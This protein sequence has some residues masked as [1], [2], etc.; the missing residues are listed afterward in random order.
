MMHMQST[1]YAYLFVSFIVL[2]MSS[3]I[4]WYW[5]GSV[6]KKNSNF[7]FLRIIMAFFGVLLCI[8]LVKI[9][10]K[11]IAGIFLGDDVFSVS[12][13]VISI[14]V[15]SAYGFYNAKNKLN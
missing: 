4:L 11:K 8:V 14:C 5:R 3:I 9:S 10:L 15:S 7:V 12:I 13:M 2:L 6:T 1:F